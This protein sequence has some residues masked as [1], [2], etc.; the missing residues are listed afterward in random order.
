MLHSL[1]GV[2]DRTITIDQYLGTYDVLRINRIEESQVYKEITGS[3]VGVDHTHEVVLKMAIAFILGLE[4]VYYN[5]LLSYSSKLEVFKDEVIANSIHSY[6][7]S[8]DDSSDIPNMD[9][10]DSNDNDPIHENDNDEHD[11]QGGDPEDPIPEMYPINP[12]EF[13]V[14]IDRIYATMKIKV[15]WQIVKS[16]VTYDDADE[17]ESSFSVAQHCE[18]RYDRN[19]TTAVSSLLTNQPV[20]HDYVT[21]VNEDLQAAYRNIR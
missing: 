7:S 18:A 13:N 14:G 19:E 17:T 6:N 8:D 2:S 3:V 16:D 21:P 15:D 12:E 11:D 5:I 10:I 20:I 4:W 9:S 1:C